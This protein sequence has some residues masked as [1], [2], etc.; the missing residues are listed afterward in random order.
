MRIKKEAIKGNREAVQDFVDKLSDKANLSKYPGEVDFGGDIV[1]LTKDYLHYAF[2]ID[3]P[4]INNNLKIFKSLPTLKNVMDPLSSVQTVWM[5]NYKDIDQTDAWAEEIN[6]E[7]NIPKRFVKTYP[8]HLRFVSIGFVLAQYTGTILFGCNYR[9][10]K[11]NFGVHIDLNL[12]LDYATG[13]DFHAS[14]DPHTTDRFKDLDLDSRKLEYSRRLH[15][16]F[17][18]LFRFA[19][20]VP[21]FRAGSVSI[22]GIDN[23]SQLAIAAHDGAYLGGNDSIK[24]KGKK[25]EI[26]FRETKDYTVIEIEGMK[27][28]DGKTGSL[29]SQPRMISTLIDEA[30]MIPE[31]DTYVGVY[32]DIEAKVYSPVG[33][34]LYTQLATLYITR[35]KRLYLGTVVDEKELVEKHVPSGIDLERLERDN[36]FVKSIQ[37]IFD[38]KIERKDQISSMPGTP[39]FNIQVY[40]FIDGLSGYLDR[41]AK[42][43]EVG[44]KVYLDKELVNKDMASM[45]SWEE[46]VQEMAGYDYSSPTSEEFVF[47]MSVEVDIKSGNKEEKIME[48]TGELSIEMYMRGRTNLYMSLEKKKEY[49]I[50]P[51][52]YIPKEPVNRFST[53]DLN[54][55]VRK[56]NRG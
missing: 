26:F 14:V 16:P 53:L 1:P 28:Y 34:L 41:E 49:L 11:D 18:S 56:L 8:L 31:G 6:K 42:G 15:T 13:D 21:L 25:T 7:L 44:Y 30:D 29:V 2:S 35:R 45:P 48:Y 33:I 55:K 32:A 36:E 5:I 17:T 54:H 9:K 19:K 38:N 20:D 46:A 52:T 12:T 27:V 39:M 37:G 43:M 50:S 22:E 40:N 24:G 51:T 47:D 10:D 4:D 23:L 3:F